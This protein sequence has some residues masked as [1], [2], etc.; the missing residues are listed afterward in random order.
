MRRGIAEVALAEDPAAAADEDTPGVKATAAGVWPLEAAASG[1]RFGKGHQHPGPDARSGGADADNVSSPELEPALGNGAPP[2]TEASGKDSE[3]ATIER[4]GSRD[5]DDHS[6]A[7]QHMNS[8][9]RLMGSAAEKETGH[10]KG[11]DSRALLHVESLATTRAK[12]GRR[13]GQTLGAESER[14][15]PPG[16][17]EVGRLI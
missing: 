5:G 17:R 1:P 2:H 13:Y 4:V 11:D 9:R 8:S 3:Q 10:R 6:R 7:W 15:R 12:E 14:A 16:M